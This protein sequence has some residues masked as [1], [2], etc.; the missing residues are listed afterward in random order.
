MVLFVLAGAADRASTYVFA[1]LL[2]RSPF[3]GWEVEGILDSANFLG[4]PDFLSPKYEQRDLATLRR[5]ARASMWD[6]RATIEA[7]VAAY[8]RMQRS[9]RAAMQ[10]LAQN[11]ILVD[12]GLFQP[13]YQLRTYQDQE[14]MV[15]NEL[16]Q[17]PNYTA[18]VRLLSGE[19][20]I[21]TNPATPLRPEHEVEARI[22]TI[23]ARMLREGITVPTAAVE[24]A[25][26][27]RHEALRARP[28]GNGAQTTGN[29]QGRPKQPP[30]LA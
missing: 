18:K 12:T 13:K 10:A 25:V 2:I 17:L 19:H 20:T 4:R 9:L 26:R 6:S 5:V 27:K 11:P 15:A 29:N 7:R 24:E 23:K 8:V 21:K 16:S 3:N 30:K 14:N 1:K 22:K 28:A